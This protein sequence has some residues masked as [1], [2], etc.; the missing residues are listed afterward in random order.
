MLF[1]SNG[2]SQIS[3]FSPDIE[4]YNGHESS[5]DLTY[6]KY[7]AHSFVIYQTFGTTEISQRKHLEQGQKELFRR[8]A[9]ITWSL[10]GFCLTL[11]L[12]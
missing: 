9:A 2:F 6:K 1:K 5:F 3:L 10:S 4:T 7:E 8:T 12:S 11:L